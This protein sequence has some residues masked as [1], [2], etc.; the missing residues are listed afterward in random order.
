MAKYFYTENRYFDK[1]LNREQSLDSIYEKANSASDG[2]LDIGDVIHFL[3][4]NQKNE[5]KIMKQSV[6]SGDL[7]RDDLLGQVLRDYNESLEYHRAKLNDND[8]TRYKHSMAIKQIKDDMV[9]AKDALLGTFG[10]NSN[11][12]ES[13]FSDLDAIDMKNPVHVKALLPLKIK[14]DPNNELSFIILDLDEVIQKALDDDEKMIVEMLRDEFQVKEIAA[15]FDITYKS[16]QYKIRKIT[17]K[18]ASF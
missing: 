5:K 6:K 11:P 10:Y 12:T 9:Y 4:R 13:P 18:I 14:F 1:L 16:C 8:G 3:V 17:E 15:A 2:D 7:K